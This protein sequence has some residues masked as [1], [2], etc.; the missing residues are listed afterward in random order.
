MVQT[1]TEKLREQDL[2]DAHGPLKGTCLPAL[3]QSPLWAPREKEQ[4]V[5]FIVLS[6]ASN[7]LFNLGDRDITLYLFYYKI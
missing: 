3:A 1:W 4:C 2:P 6:I 7:K 5:S